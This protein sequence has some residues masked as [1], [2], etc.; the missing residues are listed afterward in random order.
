VSGADVLVYLISRSSVAAKSYALTELSVVTGLPKRNRPAILPVRTDD[1]PI[2]A[3]PAA[4][5]AYTILE[6][7]GDSPAEIAVAIDRIGRAKQRRQ[8]AIGAGAVLVL[9]IAAGG[10]ATV[11]WMATP[12]PETDA[13]PVS[14]SESPAAPASASGDTSPRDPVDDY[15]EALLRRTPQD[16]RVTLTGMPG[17]GGWTAVLTLADL[18]ASQV[19]YRLDDAEVF[20]ETGDSSILNTMT[21]RPRPNTT[22]RLPGAFWRRRDVTVKYTDG[23]GVEHGPYRLDF[24]PQEQFVRFTKQALASV[25]WVSPSEL[26]PGQRIA[27]F[28]TLISFKAAFSEIRYSIDSTAADKVWPLKRTP[29]EGWPPNF[30]DE[31]LYVPVSPSAEF[32]MVKVTYLDG[33][34]DERRVDLAGR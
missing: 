25:D 6:P 34:T 7:Q 21:G 14:K 10:Y 26:S 20:T 32:L 29:G 27:H 5:R 11:R 2:E 30:S 13:V 24:N 4:L 3:I 8:L 12:D 18:S 17:N 15:N 22:I 1:T 33:S 19:R 31:Q 16:K 23:K 9:S 28:G